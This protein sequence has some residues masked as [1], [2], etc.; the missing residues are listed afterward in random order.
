MP[1]HYPTTQTM[2]ISDVRGQLNTLVNRVYRKE[3]RVIVEKSGIPVAGLV[4]AEDLRR[5]DQLD[6]RE[7][8]READFAVLD[9]LRQAFA[10]VPAEEIE[11]E[12]ERIT[13][14]IRA[15][16][17]PAA[18]QDVAAPLSSRR[19]EDAKMVA[20]NETSDQQQPPGI[21]STQ[22]PQAFYA[23][24]TQHQKVRNILAE[25]AK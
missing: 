14:E 15:M 17:G 11:R 13:A 23:D 22:S 7:R 25:L 4:S 9:E 24:L 16:Q 18:A 3:T 10:G 1:E 8:E 19:Q 6:Q 2:K 12:T 21:P 20:N 5:L